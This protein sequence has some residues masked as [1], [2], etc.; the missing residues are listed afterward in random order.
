M[1]GVLPRPP[2]KQNTIGRMAAAVPPAASI[3]NASATPGV[4]TPRSR[5]DSLAARMVI[6]R[7]LLGP[8]SADLQVVAQ[9]AVAGIP[10]E[11]FLE[12]G[13][14]LGPFLFVQERLGLLIA[15]ARGQLL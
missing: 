4:P 2:K 9:V 7:S 5:G 8:F 15:H 14:R 6:L 13:S 3:N 11:P 1:I 10:L 12:H